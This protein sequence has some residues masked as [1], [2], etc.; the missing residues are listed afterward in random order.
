[1]ST[2][3]VAQRLALLERKACQRSGDVKHVNP[4][5]TVFQRLE[6]LL[7]RGQDGVEEEIHGRDR[8]D[9]HGAWFQL[10]DELLQ[11]GRHQL[12]ARRVGGHDVG[13]RVLARRAVQFGDGPRPQPLYQRR[14]P[15]FFEPGDFHVR[16]VE[17]FVPAVLR[18]TGRGVELPFVFRPLGR[19]RD[20]TQSDLAVFP[21]E[22]RLGDQDPPPRDAVDD[23][24][25]R[26]LDAMEA[27]DLDADHCQI[28][29]DILGKF[30]V[31]QEML[32]GPRPRNSVILDL[33]AAN[34]RQ[35]I[36][37]AI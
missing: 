8:H 7:I 18:L 36:G 5:L 9:H 24:P 16:F 20:V 35:L 21:H 34:G 37:V 27:V 17:I 10:G 2:E 23:R 25:V 11:D 22:I 29:F 6:E 30:P 26:D 19:H 4:G 32:I 3:C 33:A 28:G 31:D 15:E 12:P 14:V 1:M 13:I